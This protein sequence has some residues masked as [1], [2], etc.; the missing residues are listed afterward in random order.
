VSV[1]QVKAAFGRE[2]IVLHVFLDSRTLD[3]KT[4]AQL[5][6]LQA[7]DVGAVRAAKVAER[8]QLDR[9]RNRGGAHPVIW[10]T[11]S[12]GH[13]RVTVLVFLLDVA[14]AQL[15]LAEA[16]W[17]GPAGVTLPVA[18]VRNVVVVRDA[19]ATASMASRVRRAVARLSQV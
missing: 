9:I 6:R 8:G 2:G 5:T 17:F 14:D 7:G 19:D 4:I 15:G 1:G 13:A 16:K 11:G 12:G 10:L 18:G 3:R